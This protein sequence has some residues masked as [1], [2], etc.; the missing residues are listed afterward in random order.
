MSGST[1]HFAAPI[2]TALVITELDVGG[3]ER[4]LTNL[5]IDLDR[6]RFEPEVYSLAPRPARGEDQLV[7]SLERHSVPVHFVG[8]RGSWQF[9]IGLHRL[10]RM[11][12]RQRPQI[13]QTFLFHANVTGTLAA[14]KMR[15][16]C[17]I[18]GMR[19]ADPSKRRLRI[20]QWL[21]RRV[22][23][24]VCVSMSVADHYL[25]YG[26]SPEKIQVIPNG[27]DLAGY[28]A[29]AC[30][31]GKFG[32]APNRQV[33]V[34]VGRLHQQKGLD[35]L[36]GLAPDLLR[37]LP[38]HDLLLVGHGPERARLEALAE[39]LGVHERVHFAGWQANIP[40]ILA[41][42]SVCVLPSRWEGMPNI[43]LEAMA[44]GLPFVSTQADGV[45]ELAGPE[46]KAQTVSVGDSHAFIERAA[47]IA[48]SE[49]YARELGSRNRQRIAEEFSLARMV[50]SYQRL[51]ET[52][53]R[54][55]A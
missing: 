37:E 52:S 48:T 49:T 6:S 51:Y 29:T 3:A 42:A 14:R 21:S 27:I 43:L 4:C 40:E 5:A 17:I 34:Y 24:Q 25:K 9:L 30:D 47:A 53:V 31:L 22:A 41:A 7:R 20:E 55:N 39:Q 13:V 32:V 18:N 46:A 50:E 35:W 44:T 10:G 38:E 19:V 1:P 11:L 16:C 2:R 15:D 8:V 36:L 45:M 23:R 28:P 12:R 26:V 54:A 33:L